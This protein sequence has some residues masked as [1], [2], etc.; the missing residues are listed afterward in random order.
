MT[1]SA[2]TCLAELVA[3]LWLAFLSGA[4]LV[5]HTVLLALAELEAE[6]KVELFARFDFSTI[7]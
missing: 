4:E 6:L 1:H 2:S 7:G 5:K 3:H